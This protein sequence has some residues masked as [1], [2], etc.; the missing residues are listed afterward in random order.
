MLRLKIRKKFNLFSISSVSINSEIVSSDPSDA[1]LFII[2]LSESIL[3]PTVVRFFIS[4]FSFEY[5]SR[6]KVETGEKV[7]ILMFLFLL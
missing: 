5:K 1:F 4:R 2:S 7:D 3:Y 6:K